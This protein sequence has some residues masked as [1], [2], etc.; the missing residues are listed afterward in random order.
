MS[1]EQ[2]TWGWSYRVQ[3]GDKPLP[4][5]GYCTTVVVKGWLTWNLKRPVRVADRYGYCAR[6]AVS[7][8]K[9]RQ[10]AAM[11]DGEEA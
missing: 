2:H 7:R 6:K 9:C 3:E 1:L 8:G 10:H 4:A 5:E 11:G